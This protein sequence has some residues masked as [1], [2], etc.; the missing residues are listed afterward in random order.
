MMR[1]DLHTHTSASD[2]T[3]EPRSVGE[4]AAA[5]GLDVVAVTDHDTTAGWDA[6]IA[7]APAGV[8]VVPGVEFSCV[9]GEGERRVSVHLL[10][11][12]FDRAEPRFA[13]ERRRLRLDRTDRGR[14]IVERLTTAGVPIEW[15]AVQRLAGGAPIGRPHIAGALVT[16]GA[17]STVDDA[18]ETWLRPGGPYYV[19]KR[20]V[21]VRDGIAMVL[22][23]G[24]V[25]VFAHPRARK[26]GRVVT[27]DVIRELAAAGLAGIEVDH[28]DH[29][30]A[31]RVE[32]RT[33]AGELGLIMTGSSDYHGTNK[34]VPLGANTT[35]PQA[36][37]EVCRRASGTQPA[38]C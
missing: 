11:Y 35:D 33:L 38:H 24:G 27:D 17:S 21:D 15:P 8:T 10:G 30:A 18:F 4:L 13:A 28:V 14:R 3:D 22:A 37:A 16:A 1:I 36:Y 9:V 23:A 31:D 7:G 12:L 32:L 6:A 2:G 5:V 26:R 25:P 19:R 29:D 20:D 34:A